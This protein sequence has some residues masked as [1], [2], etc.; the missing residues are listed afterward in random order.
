MNRT[1][2]LLSDKSYATSKNLYTRR[3]PS[4]KDIGQSQIIDVKAYGAYGDGQTDDTAVLNSI[5][6]IAG[7]LSSI[8]FF[9]FGVYIISEH[10]ALYQYQLSGA[11]DILMG[12]IQTESPYFQAIPA[13][14]APFPAIFPN[15]PTFSNCTAGSLLCSVS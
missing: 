13:A 10:S 1:T 2:S 12:M 11:K 3:R 4:Y 15:D 5:L 9:P 8:V 6:A 14:P 7:N